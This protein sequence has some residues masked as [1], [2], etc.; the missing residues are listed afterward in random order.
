MLRVFT[1]LTLL[2][3][4]AAISRGQSKPVTVMPAKELVTYAPKPQL[5]K[6]ATDKHLSGAGVCL[7]EI[8]PDGTVQRATMIQSTGELLLDKAT[9][10]CFSKWRFLPGKVTKVQIPITYWGNDEKPNASNRS[11][12]RLSS[13]PNF[14]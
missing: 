5:P 1:V 4:G 12:Q 11:R 14:S 13:S 7:L 6:Q 9:T 2:V 3:I 10:D 8:R